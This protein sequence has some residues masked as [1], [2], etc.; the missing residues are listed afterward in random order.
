LN[1][2]AVLHHQTTVG[3]KL[4]ADAA[5]F[6]YDRFMVVA[7]EIHGPDDTGAFAFP[8]ADAKIAIEDD[9]A[10]GSLFQRT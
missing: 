1:I 9:T 4:D 7:V 6:A 5:V 8:T 2:F 3:A 10:A